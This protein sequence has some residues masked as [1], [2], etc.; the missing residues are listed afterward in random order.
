MLGTPSLG[1]VAPKLPVIQQVGV[2][3]VQ[4]EG[5]DG[6]MA[7]AQQNLADALPKAVRN[8]RRFRVLSD[9]LVAGLWQDGNGRKELAGEFELHAFTSLTVAP[10]GDVVTMTARLLDQNL[11]TLLIESDTVTRNWLAAA[12]TDAAYGAVEKLVFGLYN[13]IPVD[14]SVTSVQGTYITLSGGQ[15]Q[16]IE[17][18]DNVD[19]VRATVRSIHPANGSWL[20]F[21]R[22]PLGTAKVI[23]VKN[24]T[25]VAQLVKLTA[26]N[27]VEVGDGAKIPAIAG[28]A[29]FARLTQD[30]GLKDSGDPNTIIVPP[31]YQGGVPAK[32]APKPTPQQPMKPAPKAVAQDNGSGSTEYQQEPLP[33]QEAPPPAVA[34]DEPPPAQ[35]GSTDDSFWDQVSFGD[36]VPDKLVDDVT[37]YTGPQ[38]WS[39]KSSDFSASGRFP[40]WLVNHFGANVT[41]TL[42]YKIKVGFGAGLLV[43]QTAKG[44]YVGYDSHARIYWED[45]L[46]LGD[47]FVTGWHGGVTGTFSG[48]SVSKESYGGGDSV[49]GGTFGGLMGT[50]HAGAA[51]ERYDWFADFS[52]M[53]L[54][55]GRIGYAG[56][57]K[58]IES[59]FGWDLSL[60][61]FQYSAPGL[62][63]WGGGLDVGQETQT[64]KNGRRPK[65]NEYAIKALAKVS[66]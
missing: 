31:L 38:W 5:D 16:G 14:V 35:G 41:R 39:V 28:R 37:L 48:M 17:A 66:L 22:H 18:G 54:N 64:L 49:R 36:M 55:I 26:E 19:L 27:S 33:Q 25:A 46:N 65:V 40:W 47:G 13:R 45:A 58:V 52:V 21:G 30:E 63:Q 51:N 34:G 8:A 57:R 62:I 32:A 60:G 23:E 6:G 59:S 3:P 1:A 44:N 4:W 15:E 10:R 9:D 7:T 29:K 50:V 20:E 56:S 53:P 24:H 61:A 42:F 12:S 2:V 11:K 43:G